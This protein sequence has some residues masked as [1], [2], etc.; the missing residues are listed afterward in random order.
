MDAVLGELVRRGGGDGMGDEQIH[1][2]GQTA[3]ARQDA[4]AVHLAQ[5]A[6]DEHV[7]G[8]IAG[9]DEGRI[10]LEQ[11]EIGR[12]GVGKAALDGR[13]R[14]VE[15]AVEIEEGLVGVGLGGRAVGRAARAGDHDAQTVAVHH[16]RDHLGDLTV[17]RLA[18]VERRIVGL[19]ALV[20]GEGERL[21]LRHG[22][23]LGLVAQLLR[24]AVAVQA[25][26]LVVVHGDGGNAVDDDGLDADEIVVLIDGGLGD[27]CGAEPLVNLLSVLGCVIDGHGYHSPLS[28]S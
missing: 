3:A 26:A 13:V 7:L 28:V 12:G 20:H 8:Q 23:L 22:Q 15:H 24:G 27:G 5:L 25:G 4:H 14:V 17:E 6:G 9:A 2:V 11:L 10:L 18:G 16:G 1:A 19:V 21:V